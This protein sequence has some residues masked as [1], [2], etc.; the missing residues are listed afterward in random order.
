[1]K[2]VKVPQ[3]DK[4]VKLKIVRQDGSDGKVT[5]NYN[6]ASPDFSNHAQPGID[7]KSKEGTLEF[8]HNETEKVIEIEIIEKELEDRD[9][10]FAVSLSLP[11][12]SQGGKL[13]KKSMVYVEIVG[14]TEVLSAAKGIDE[15]IQF[16]QQ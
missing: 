13:S 2:T 1:M 7:Y 9:D 16:M 4:V 3:S 11:D 8:L 6:T 5:V 12:P 15:M 10:A 14:K